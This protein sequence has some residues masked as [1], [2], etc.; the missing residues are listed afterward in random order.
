MILRI[1][2]LIGYRCSKRYKRDLKIERG[3]QHRLCI[4]CIRCCGKGNEPTY[5]KDIKKKQ[6]DPSDPQNQ[7]RALTSREIKTKVKELAKN[8][9]FPILHQAGY[10]KKKRNCCAVLFKRKRRKLR[11]KERMVRHRKGKTWH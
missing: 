1:C 11:K 2:S 7:G 5:I 6:L 10:K 3:K 4:F 9:K 8:T